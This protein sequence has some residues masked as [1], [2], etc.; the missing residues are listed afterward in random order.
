MKDESR[1]KRRPRERSILR[2]LSRRLPDRLCYPEG[3][4]RDRG[5]YPEGGV[6]DHGCFPERR[7]DRKRG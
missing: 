3:G 7:P 1:A 6:G 5:C 4:V 2:Q